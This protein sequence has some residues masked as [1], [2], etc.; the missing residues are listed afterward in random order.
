MRGYDCPC[1]RYLEADDDAALSARIRE[2]ADADHPEERYTDT[3]LELMRE[4]GAY[5]ALQERG[6]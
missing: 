3:Q 4:Q 6:G 5:D 2:H 1:G